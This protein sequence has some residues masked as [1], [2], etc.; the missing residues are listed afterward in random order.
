M[1][2]SKWELLVIFGAFGMLIIKYVAPTSPIVCFLLLVIVWFMYKV[3]N[4]FIE[5]HKEENKHE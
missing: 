2:V 1:K 4:M 3:A 5:E